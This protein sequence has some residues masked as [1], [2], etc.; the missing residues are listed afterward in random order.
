MTAMVTDPISW[1]A[2][3]MP[4]ERAIV[5]GDAAVSY[6]ELDGWVSRVAAGYA[7]RGVGV[8]DRVGVIGPNSLQWCVAALAVI[9]AGAILVP[10][11]MRLVVDELDDLVA[12][13]TPVLVVAEDGPLTTTMEA[14]AARGRT[15]DLVG[16]SFVDQFRRPGPD[17]A[18]RRDVDPDQPAVIVYTSG[19]TAKPK[20]VIFSHT[21]TFNFI[22]EWSLV[23]PGFCRGMRLLMVLPIHGAPGTLWGL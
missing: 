13:S 1:W 10:L 6:G 8:G 14:V 5:V 19:T 12:G 17:S 16:L 23:E 22:F 15:F 9:R 4:H 7:E 3:E 2:Q 11:N 18:F 20:G 21:T